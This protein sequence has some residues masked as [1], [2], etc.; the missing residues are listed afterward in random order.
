MGLTV[1]MF[2]TRIPNRNANYFGSLSKREKSRYLKMYGLYS[3]LL[4][5]YMDIK[6]ELSKL[7]DMI[8]KSKNG[9]KPIDS[10]L[11]DMYQYLAG[12]Y[13]KYFYIRNNLYIE[14]LCDE[15][16]AYLESMTGVEEGKHDDNTAAFRE[17]TYP[18]VCAENPQSNGNVSVSYGSTA[19]RF[20]KPDNAFIL[21][22]RFDEYYLAEGETDKDWVEKNNMRQFEYELTEMGVNRLYKDKLKMPVYLIKY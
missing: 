1:E 10:R 22:F 12:K 21:G 2:E 5:N 4:Y 9:F 14:R 6:L 15:D 19:Y 3:D 7:D 17:R 8:A 18:L 11:W 20:F 13:L 16:L